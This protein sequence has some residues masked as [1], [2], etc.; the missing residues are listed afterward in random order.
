MKLNNKIFVIGIIIVVLFPALAY[1]YTSLN[2]IIINPRIISSGG[3]ASSFNYSLRNVTIGKVLSGKIQSASYTLDAVGVEGI[4][5]VNPPTVNAVTTPTNISTQTISGTKEPDT[6]IYINGYEAVPLD[7]NTF[8]SYE[9]SLSEGN[10]YFIVTARDASGIESDS[11]TVAI[12]LDANPPQAPV[13][14]SVTTPTNISTQTISGTKEAN[15]SIWI[16]G[17]ERVLIDSSGFWSVSV[18]LSEGDNTLNITAKDAVSN[19]SAITQANI[20]LDTSAPAIPQVSDDGVY[21]TS[22]AQLHA[23]WSADDDETGIA[24]Y[25]YA[26]GLTVGGADVVGWTSVGLQTEITHTGLNLIQ[27]QIYY[28]SVKAKNGAGSWSQEGVSDGITIN[29]NTPVISD[30]QPSNASTGYAGDDIIF[31]VTAQDADGDNLSYQ[32]SADGEII[33]S[34]QAGPGFNW[35]TS[36]EAPGIHTIKTEVSDNNGAIVSQDTEICLFYQPPAPPA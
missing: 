35:P 10:N 16:N 31:S 6:S 36:E 21:T 20:L 9:V 11:V 22:A 34:W 3:T 8:W 5:L 25:Q 33:Q 12:A 7:N 28:I 24:E 1:S 30:I 13:I 4:V 19:A 2:Y 32:F 26:I 17:I 15:T 23:S 29:Q 14:S 18:S 27:G